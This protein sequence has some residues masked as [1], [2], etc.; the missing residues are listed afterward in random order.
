MPLAESAR[1][2][3]AQGIVLAV[4]AQ[5]AFDPAALSTEQLRLTIERIRQLG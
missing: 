3:A 1:A 2:V 5:A 4:S